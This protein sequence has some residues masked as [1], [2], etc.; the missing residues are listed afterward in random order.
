MSRRDQIRMTPDEVRRFLESSKTIVLTSNGTQG[1]PHPMPMWFTLE[2]DGTV[3]MTTYRVSQKIKNLERDPRLTLLA[4][5]G[6]EYSELRGVVIHGRAE[7]A[8]DTET[9]IE[10]LLAASGQQDSEEVRTALQ[11]TAAK[12]VVIRVKP[13]R[14]VSWDHRKLGGVY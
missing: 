6:T 14:T 3:R 13:E 11:R 12:R 2:S 8:Y 9:V 7:L 10:T 5:A 4:E 1:Y